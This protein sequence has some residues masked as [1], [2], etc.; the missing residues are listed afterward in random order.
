MAVHFCISHSYITKKKKKE[1][2][3]MSKS[4]RNIISFIIATC[5]SLFKVNPDIFELMREFNVN[6]PQFMLQ[7]AIKILTLIFV[8][9]F[10]SRII[11]A[12]SAFIRVIRDVKD[13]KN[14][15]HNSWD[16]NARKNNNEHQSTLN[17]GINDENHWD[18]TK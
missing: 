3:V 10:A 4:M 15:G 1:K 5:I 13:E 16:D 12:I 18:F 17:G 7:I 8:F 6:D 9:M 2:I 14:N 11:E